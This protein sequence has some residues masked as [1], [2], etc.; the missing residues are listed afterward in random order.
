MTVPIERRPRGRRCLRIIGAAFGAAALAIG[1]SAVAL[2]S[3]TKPASAATVSFSQCNDRGP[4][5]GGAPLTVSCSVQIVNTITATGGTSAVVYV[6]SCTLNACTGDVTSSSDLINAVHQCNGSD[7]VGG[8]TTICSVNIVNNI[9]SSAPSAA[10]GL[11]R[12]QCIGSGG[13]GGTNMTACI[14]SSNGS[15]TVSQCNGSGNG[16]GGMMTCTASGRVSPDFPITVDQCN[17][18]ENGGGS[19]VTCTT[20]IT[21]NV[22]DTDGESPLIPVDLIPGGTPTTAPPGESPTGTPGGATPGAPTE[23]PGGAQDVFPT[24]PPILNELAGPAFPIGQT[25]PLTGPPTFTG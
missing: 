24:A 18:S 7:N 3:H 25:P 19:F 22:I 17:G 1:V 23:G 8:S 14:P 2:E 9:S 16:G 21:T 11:T 12:N 20:T 15:A 5:P 10:T 6:R 13:G 4:G